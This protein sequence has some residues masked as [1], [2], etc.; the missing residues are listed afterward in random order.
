M[1]K[2]FI[3]SVLCS[4]ITFSCCA[5]ADPPLELLIETPTRSAQPLDR[6]LLHSTVISQQDILDSQTVDVPS[7]LKKLAGVEIYQSGGVGQQSSLF[8][9]GTNSSH[10]LVLLDGV[11]INSATTGMTE[12]DQLML[13]QVERIEVVRGNVSSLYGS[14]AIGGVI[15]IFTRQGKGKPHFNVS[16]GFGSHAERRL[17]A[18][19]G[20]ESR[21]TTYNLRASKYRADGV[22]SI[23]ADFVPGVN[24]DRDG[25][26][27]TS[28]SA[29]IRHAFMPDHSLSASLFN[30]RGETQT[31]NSFGSSTD[32][33]SSKATIRKVALVLEDRFSE[34]WQS[35]LQI[36]QGADDM[37]N[38]LN[39]SPDIALGAQFKTTSDQF[40]WQNTWQLKDR[41]VANIGIESLDQKVSSSTVFTRDHRSANSLFAGYIGHHELHQYQF[42]V[43]QDRYADFGTANTGLLG[44]GYAI[45]AAWRV[46]TSVSTAFKAPTINDMYY[47][48]TDFGF[49][50]SY[51]GNPDLKPEHSRNHELGLH[52]SAHDQRVDAVYFDNHI[53][54][55]I[56][57]NNQPASTMI[58]L[59]E[60][61]IDG[62]ELVY[63]GK[64]GDTGVDLAVTRQNPRDRATGEVLLRRAKGYGN[65]GVTQQMG[66]WRVAAEAQYSGTR[67]DI[68][69]NTFTRT[70]LD[71][72]YLVN[73]TASHAISKQLDLSLRAGNLFDR[74]YMLAHGYNTLGRT[75][76][77]GL[78]YQP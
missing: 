50:Y 15:Q 73:L 41:D 59:A 31:D 8:L 71:S 21:D 17:A 20:G 52:Y 51:Q 46:S 30:S 33:N 44:Y 38:F 18:G 68:D 9:R 72:Y 25:Y 53:R 36:A 4:A 62:V 11:R 66:A 58:N 48:Y 6:S 65:V 77:V 32:V 78:N 24:P 12:I 56:S 19:F 23:R 1:K 2:R 5:Y 27:N 63:A 69:I 57:N 74:D 49:G 22:S 35:K 10:V 40:S 76:Y 55:L 3:T 34:T 47:P 43:R 13:D 7:A 45:N 39:G 26:D 42:N 75:L 64:F 70:T 14:E 29:N 54:D 60:A 16:G 37:Q 28:L 61:R 67:A